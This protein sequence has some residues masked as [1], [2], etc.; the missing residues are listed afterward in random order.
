MKKL[1]LIFFA[2]ISYPIIAFGQK[3]STYDYNQLEATIRQGDVRGTIHQVESFF[4]ERGYSP[5]DSLVWSIE[6]HTTLYNYYDPSYVNPVIFISN[7]PVKKEVW[8][9]WNMW[10]RY[11]TDGRFKPKKYFKNAKQ[12]RL[13]ANYNVLMLLSHEYGHH[14]ADRYGVKPGLLNAHEFNADLASIALVESFPKQSDL[15]RLQEKYIELIKH[16]NNLVDIDNRFPVLKT[17]L[18][19]DQSR[20]TVVYPKDTA[21]MAQYASAYFVR[22]IFFHENSNP[23]R[24]EKQLDSILR[25]QFRAWNYPSLVNVTALTTATYT[26]MFDYDANT[27]WRRSIIGYGSREGKRVEELRTYGFDTE[28]TP[29]CVSAVWPREQIARA[30][31]PIEVR[32]LSGALLY[33]WYCSWDTT[34]QLSGV[35]WHGFQLD[36][37]SKR[38]S[39]LVGEKDRVGEQRF[40]LYTSVEDSLYLKPIRLPKEMRPLNYRLMRVQDHKVLLLASEFGTKGMHQYAC[41]DVDLK[42][43]TLHRQFLF[44]LP[45]PDTWL[46]NWTADF[47]SSEIGIIAREQ[48]LLKWE[49]GSLTRVS[50][51]GLPGN[52]GNA[53]IE[54]YL[55]GALFMGEDGI[56]MIDFLPPEGTKRNR[57]ILFLRRISY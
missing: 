53:A 18:Y 42:V 31:I 13:M 12:A 15:S 22:R 54:F 5:Q 39:I 14:L 57:P 35:K 23:H 55:P 3:H 46:G 17:N 36:V 52:K 49:N 6:P 27:S 37:K 8:D 47:Q 25:V 50:G 33:R 11:I 10:S 9:Y 4:T 34:R 21:L 2:L 16:L 7:Y 32:S 51:T 28:G 45:G 38:F 19:I 1:L 40:V 56:G 29:I 43:D 48:F 24:A 20:P 44:E 26:S 41:F 30:I